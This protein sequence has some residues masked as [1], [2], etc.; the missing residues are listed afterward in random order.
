MNHLEIY[1]NGQQTDLGEALKV[2][3]DKVVSE[4]RNPL[5]K[6]G[7][8][9]YTIKFPDTL[10]NKGI[11]HYQQDRAVIG[12]FRKQYDCEVYC[13]GELILSGYFILNKLTKGYFEGFI[14]G[15][16]GGRISDIVEEKLMLRDI[17]SFT[18]IDY[19][20]DYTVWE[21]MDRDLTANN[22]EVAFPFVLDSF[23]RLKYMSGG[24]IDG[25][26]Q[27]LRFDHF[28]VSHFTAAVFKNIFADQGY[29]L[30][31]SVLSSDAFN[32]LL[33]FYTDNGDETAYNYA[34]LNILSVFG[35]YHRSKSINGP[36]VPDV[37]AQDYKL[38]VAEPEFRDIRN[39][40]DPN[41]ID[42]AKSGDTAYCMGED[43]VYTC[44]YT[45]N[46]T[47][48]LKSQIPV[49]DTA[50]TAIAAKQFLVFREIGNDKY[51]DGSY[52][53]QNYNSIN[54]D[55][56]KDFDTLNT[57]NEPDGDGIRS[58]F[59]VRLVAGRQYRVQ[60][61]IFIRNTLNTDGLLLHA[62]NA[63]TWLSITHIDGHQQLNPARFLPEMSQLDFV[64]ALFKLFNLYYQIDEGNK[65]VS[66]FSRDEFFE[67]SKANILDISN[68]LNLDSF[69]ETPLSEGEI[70]ETY[71][72][73][74]T[75]E[76]D[77]LL[78]RTDYMDTVNGDTPEE[79]YELP[80]APLGFLAVKLKKYGQNMLDF[81]EAYDLL[82]AAI[83]A[84][85][86]T[87][88]S[89]LEDYSA[90]SNF[91]YKPKLALYMGPNPLTTGS[92]VISDT[93]SNYYLRLRTVS[94]AKPM[95]RLVFFNIKEQPAYEVQT[96]LPTRE[97]FVNDFTGTT[98]YQSENPLFIA[99]AHNAGK[100]DVTSLANTGSKSMFQKL[101]QNDLAITDWSNFTEGTIKMDPLLY[102]RL[103]G[104][105]ILCIEDDLYLL[106][107]VK[108]YD[109]TGNTAKV[110][111]Y[112]MVSS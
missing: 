27:S 86:I 7:T 2:V 41:I 59:T 29:T 67:Q 74:S 25:T 94:T 24:Y 71:F 44:N 110:K 33:M 64:N 76:S 97:F 3:L 34:R 12:K 23:A 13:N 85:D 60:V 90:S 104:R 17:K 38:Y 5:K 9:S 88:M 10:K 96:N 45:S 73:W 55:S 109:P 19:L 70:A 79:A 95:P 14:T 57:N 26:P 63:H 105:N 15:S 36:M 72:K 100:L 22:S 32:R 68:R 66:L 87:D 99:D 53:Y 58:N 112:K 40:F 111:L 48:R 42:Y 11:F 81:Q 39:V 98:V 1:I 43:G 93:N 35:H 51:A 47:F 91:G 89:V 103:N 49:T 31:G 61:Y 46:Y 30:N 21:N 54:F 80:F 83:P 37:E 18:P 52:K 106:E 65:M 75:D 8:Y 92:Y 78:A 16:K 4:F 101:Y 20:G 82:P 84:T 50:G 56:I 62:V 6:T 108:S 102:N 77:Y 28:G 69:E 107:S